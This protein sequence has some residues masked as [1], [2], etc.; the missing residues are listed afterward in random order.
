MELNQAAKDGIH[1]SLQ[2][3]E[4]L[5]PLDKIDPLPGNPRRGNVDAVVASYK[6]F[7]Q[8]KPIVLQAIEGGDRFVSTAGN[9][10]VKAARQLGWS[11]IS[12]VTTNDDDAKAAAFAIADN[13]THDLGEYDDEKVLDMINEFR[14]NDELLEAASVDLFYVAD[15]EDH[16]AELVASVNAPV[17]IPDEVVEQPKEPRVNRPV[18]QH[19]IVFNNEDEQGRWFRFVRWLRTEYPELETIG[20]RLD[21]YIEGLG[22]E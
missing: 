19:T 12:A 4:L 1:P 20:E 14:Y 13:R 6:E 17:E 3:P 8:R 18:I 9:T 22:I 21:A 2:I 15:L 10:Q 5:V 16:V 7:G 11:H